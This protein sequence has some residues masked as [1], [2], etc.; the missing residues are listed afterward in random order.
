[1]NHQPGALHKSF[2]CAGAEQVDHNDYRHTSDIIR[3]DG[4]FLSLAEMN[5][6]FGQSKSN[7]IKAAPPEAGGIVPPMYC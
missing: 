5:L 4:V 6:R 7:N 3:K 2:R 1:V